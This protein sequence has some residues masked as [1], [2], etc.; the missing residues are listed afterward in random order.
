MGINISSDILGLDGQCVNQIKL[1]GASPQIVITCRRD[2]R[3][4]AI[5]PAT[6]KKG[7]INGS[8]PL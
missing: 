7:T 1:S 6:G 3:R 5:D 4:S 2:R 8:S